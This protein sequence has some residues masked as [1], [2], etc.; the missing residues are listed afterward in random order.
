[1]KNSHLSLLSLIVL[2]MI[3][4]FIT[5]CEKETFPSFLND[6]RSHQ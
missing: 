3:S 1:M 5:S 4:I 2:I 6:A